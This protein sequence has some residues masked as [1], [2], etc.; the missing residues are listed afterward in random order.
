[1]LH[2]DRLPNSSTHS[3]ETKE[4]ERRYRE[5]VVDVKNKFETKYRCL[6]IIFNIDAY[7]L[8]S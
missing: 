7:V 4:K 3:T 8:F 6:C 1:M 5:S 2:R